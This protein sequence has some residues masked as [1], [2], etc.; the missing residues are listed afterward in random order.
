MHTDKGSAVYTHYE[1]GKTDSKVSVEQIAC[2]KALFEVF[3][4]LEVPM[5]DINYNQP[6]TLPYPTENPFK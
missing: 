4:Y 1:E 6:A 3:K 5:E 2:G